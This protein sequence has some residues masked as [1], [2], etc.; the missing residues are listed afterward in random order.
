MSSS[1]GADRPDL[2]TSGQFGSQTLLSAKALRIYA[3]NGLLPPYQVD[4]VNGYR[5]YAP[6]QIQLGWLIGL[7]RSADLS[8]EQIGQI[9]GTDPGTGLRRLERAVAAV[10]RRTA[11][12]HAVL[13]RARLHLSQED[14]MAQIITA[15]EPDRPV[16]SV[17]RRMRPDQ[18]DQ[19]IPFEVGELRNAAAAGGLTETGD[20]FGIFHAPITDDSDGPLEIV[21]PVDG[22][23]D[24]DGEVRSYRLSGGLVANR[25]A[26]GSE[27]DFPE[28]L[29]LYDEV[30]SWITGAGRVPVGPPREIW[31]NSPHD[32]EPL[33][34]TISWPYAN[35]PEAAP[36]A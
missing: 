16:L 4:P 21:L 17:L 20:A 22:L 8:L 9:V 13:H 15:L 28:I 2:L 18:M 35:P 23:A 1:N 19:I 25:N 34:L 26:E 14:T 29:A 36:P 5:Y 30:H 3:D 12:V 11:A 6:E 31:H 32:P 27:T 10:D 7:L 24:V 33:R